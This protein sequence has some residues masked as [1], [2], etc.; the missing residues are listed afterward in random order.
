MFHTEKRRNTYT[1]GFDPMTQGFYIGF[2]HVIQDY[3]I[4][5]DLGSSEEIKV[6]DNYFIWYYHE[7][8]GEEK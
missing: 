1:V 7:F 2:D 6:K 3:S 5:L 4:G 8:N